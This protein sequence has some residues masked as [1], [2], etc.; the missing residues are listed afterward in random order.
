[1]S[2]LERRLTPANSRAATA[3]SMAVAILAAMAVTALLFAAYHANPLTAFYALFHEPFAT[4]RGFGYALV[5]AAPLTMIALGT[6][7][8]WRSGFGYLGFEGC[9]VIGSAGA[10]WAALAASPGGL[11][12]PLPFLVFLPLV[13]MVSFLCGGLWAA[14]VG[15][16]RV[17]LGGN[18]VLISLMMN[19]VAILIVQY[20]VSGPMRAA[21]SLPET[22]RFPAATW[23]PFLFPTSGP[24]GS[25]A[26]FGIV[27]AIAAAALV[28][29][30]LR[31]MTLGYELIVTG[32]N[33]AAARYAGINAGRRIILAA[34]FGGGLG[35]LAGMMELLGVQHRLMD[36]ISG[37]VGFIGMIV[38][39]LARL[40][41][42][43]VVPTAI[44]YGGMTVGADAMQ[45]RAAIPSS[46]NL[47]L[48][49]LIVLFLLASELF[50][51]YRINWSALRPKRSQRAA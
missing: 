6:I 10:A 17:R 25:R 50:L 9:F 12:G 40:N 49:S 36:G 11:I 38:A 39:L 32:F 42:L 26:H 13:L 23:M 30:L 5:K 18:E 2:L 1:M 33:P 19:Y 8:C 27:I 43:A 34:F 41:P 20:L 37:G 47:I 7:V 4:F 24:H 44:L 35:G 21:G 15:I 29:M 28:W 14:L 22:E 45:R 48:Q 51:R 16:V 46:V 31:R 3:A